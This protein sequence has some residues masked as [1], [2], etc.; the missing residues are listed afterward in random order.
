MNDFQYPETSQQQQQYSQGTGGLSGSELSQ[1]MSPQTDAKATRSISS[2]PQSF[3]NG[4]K[5]EVSQYSQSPNFQTNLASCGDSERG[6]SERGGVDSDSG[7]LW[8]SDDE[9]YVGVF[10]YELEFSTRC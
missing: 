2:R 3:Q 4:N 5:F 9:D 7:N 1:N 6:G 10:G 8:R